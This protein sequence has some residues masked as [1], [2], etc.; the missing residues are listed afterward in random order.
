MIS[1]Y[2]FSLKPVVVDKDHHFFLPVDYCA[3]STD[4]L[5]SL[6]EFMKLNIFE[7]ENGKYLPQSVGFKG[8]VEFAKDYLTQ[9]QLRLETLYFHDVA[10][11]FHPVKGVLSVAMKL[12]IVDGFSYDQTSYEQIALSAALHDIGNIVERQKH[13][14]ISME[15]SYETL[16]NM[17]YDKNMINGVANGVFGTAIDFVDGVPCRMVNSR[18][19]KI[20][21]D[22]DLNNAG[23]F[24]E[25]N[26]AIESIKL[27]LEMRN[28]PIEDFLTKG[29]ELSTTF[30]NNL[31]DY[32]TD[33]ARLLFSEQRQKNLSSLSSEVA[34]I[35]DECEMDIDLLTHL[36]RQNDARFLE[37]I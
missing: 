1:D 14:R 30:F 6:R 11:T 3:S 24:D 21:S 31:G 27:W 8:V 36:L 23:F 15:D 5:E 12:A 18:E 19:A 25:R 9:D 35:L 33:S 26:F 29:V 22:A 4:P 28:I 2:P 20:V 17:G 7:H 16:I 34:H 32:Y 13:E 10:H 37:P